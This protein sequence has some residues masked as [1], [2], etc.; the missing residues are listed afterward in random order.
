M[1]ASQPSDPGFLFRAFGA[2]TNLPLAPSTLTIAEI[3]L[4]SSAQS[5]D[6]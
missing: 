2:R 3:D 1:S 5:A 4:R 6:N